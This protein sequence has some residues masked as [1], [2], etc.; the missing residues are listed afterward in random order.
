MI[1]DK[2]Y[3]KHVYNRIELIMMSCEVFFF[4][5]SVLLS[6]QVSR[7][8]MK[9]IQ[10]RPV[11]TA[12]RGISSCVMHFSSPYFLLLIGWTIWRSGEKFDRNEQKIKESYNNE[13]INLKD[14]K[15]QKV[16]F[17]ILTKITVEFMNN[18]M[19]FPVV[20]ILCFM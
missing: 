13:E 1:D 16:G 14:W 8:V 15:E 18:I 19:C 7:S 10:G 5:S 9:E 3:Y 12:S 11:S 17:H 6:A 20:I 4:T 2:W